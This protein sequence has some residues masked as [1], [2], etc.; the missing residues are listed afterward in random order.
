MDSEKVK[1]AQQK[2][3]FDEALGQIATTDA[4]S[5]R[6]AIQASQATKPSLH[7]RFVYDP[8]KGRA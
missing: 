7:T 4:V 1:F 3:L 6:A 8:A 2:T 5:S